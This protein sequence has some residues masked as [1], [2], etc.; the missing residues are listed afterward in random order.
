MPGLRTFLL[1]VGIFHLVYGLISF[2]LFPLPRGIDPLPVVIAVASGILRT[3]AVSIMLYNLQKEEVSRVIPVVYTYPIFVALIAVGVLGEALTYWQ[4]LAII[5]VIAGAVMVSVRQTPAGATIWLGK[6]LLLLFGSSL[7]FALAD[8]TSKYALTYISFWNMFSITAFC[9]S[10]GFLLVAVRPSI[11]SKLYNLRQRSLI[12]ALLTFDEVLAPVGAVLLFWA[13]ERGLVS[14]VSTI[15]SSRPVFVVI[16][17][18]ILS[19]ILPGF[20]Q[21]QLG[22]GMLALRLLGTVMIVGGI[23]IIYLT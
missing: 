13:L 5:I 8:I 11:L 17:A 20:L 15:A 19:R 18:F 22:K 12:I 9:L 2:S 21:W 4:W 10:G 23:A 1:P 3:G 16:F 7:L 14:L 6:P